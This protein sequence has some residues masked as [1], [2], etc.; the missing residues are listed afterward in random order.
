M[1]KIIL[2]VVICLVVTPFPISPKA[3]TMPCSMILEPADKELTNAKG[4]AL[5]YKVQLRPPSF[6]RTNISILG[7]HLPEPKTYG[8]FDSYEGFAF[9]PNVIS[10]RFRLYP[11][12]EQ[13]SP[14]WAG[15][16]DEIT[17]KMENVEVQIR[18]S[19]SKTEKLGPSL[20]TGKMNNCR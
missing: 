18:L 7:V 2:V 6:P 16:F 11:T 10:W 1:K 13:E 19:N 5:I 20:L 9:V 3:E 8:P 4:V 14:S 15:R 17:A 12:P